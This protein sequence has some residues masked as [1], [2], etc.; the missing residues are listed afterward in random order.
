MTLSLLALWFLQVERLA[1]GKKKS[2]D[3]SV[4]GA[5][6]LHGVAALSGADCA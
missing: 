5:V 1:I 4:A 2:G 6:D 3:H